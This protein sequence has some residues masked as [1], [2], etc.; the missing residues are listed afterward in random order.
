MNK[1][2][3]L[4]SHAGYSVSQSKH[5]L[6]NNLDKNHDPVDLIESACLDAVGAAPP[7]DKILSKVGK[8]LRFPVHDDKRG[9]KSGALKLIDK[10]G[11][12]IFI[13]KSHRAG[14]TKTGSTRTGNRSQLT[15][16]EK[17]LAAQ[18]RQEEKKQAQLR[19]ERK[20]RM[21]SAMAR[22]IWAGCSRP[23]TWA[24]PHPYIVHKGIPPLNVRRFQSRKKDCLILPMIDPM[25]GLKSLYL[26]HA[27]GFKRPL[28]GTQFRGL[29][30]AIGHDLSTATLL[31]V[32]EGW[33]TGV[34][35]H[36]LTGDHIVIAF[37]ASNL[38][39]VIDQLVIKYPKIEIRL[40]ADDDRKTLAKTGKNPGIEYAQQV[41]KKHP[42]ISLYK[43]IFESGAPINLS[44][45]NDAV[46]WQREHGRT[47]Q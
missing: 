35:L 9:T 15:S 14:I 13:V 33:A 34:S 19:N 12:Y 28:K 45:V 1:K 30:M 2:P 5:S 24:T 22:R 8:W 27:N 47:T 23:D 25:C 39:P 31:W 42:Q 36:Q 10:G 26:I 18:Q 4:N 44:D 32:V 29:C 11:Y 20:S 6:N 43:P 46:N 40:C 7:R 37:S 38:Q 17:R 41:Q 16:E 3:L 21:L